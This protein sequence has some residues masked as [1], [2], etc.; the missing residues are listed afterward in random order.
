LVPKELCKKQTIDFV[1]LCVCV[2]L[3]SG[4][5]G[6]WWALKELTANRCILISHAETGHA[7]LKFLLANTSA[8]TFL[9]LLQF[10]A[11]SFE[12]KF[13]T[14]IECQCLAIIFWGYALLEDSR[15][16]ASP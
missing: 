3:G 9:G 8:R 2:G 12:P 1:M 15:G 11:E 5:A 6:S 13:E 10:L 16:H 4:A 7:A 14:L